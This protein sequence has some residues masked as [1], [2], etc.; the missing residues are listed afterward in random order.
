[1]LS[2]SHMSVLHAPESF[3]FF[4]MGFQDFRGGQIISARSRREDRMGAVCVWMEERNPAVV[5]H[6]IVWGKS[7]AGLADPGSP[8]LRILH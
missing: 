3:F 6:M 1:M 8:P 5:D 2:I 7:V 4:G